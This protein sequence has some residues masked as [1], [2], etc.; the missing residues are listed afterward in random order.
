MPY[1]MRQGLVDRNA[2]SDTHVFVDCLPTCRQS[3]GTRKQNFGFWPCTRGYSPRSFRRPS[4]PA[5]PCNSVDN[6]SNFACRS[7]RVHEHK[8]G[9][10]TV[11]CDVCRTGSPRE[12]LA[13]TCL[14]APLSFLVLPSQQL[15]QEGSRI[16]GCHCK[17]QPTEKAGFRS[18]CS[19]IYIH[20]SLT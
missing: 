14:E 5:N 20:Q 19:T 2:T 7:T 12:S 18:R 3:C 6:N 16:T 11:G 9:S 8:R 10:Y 17:G 13:T 4:S 1:K 15:L